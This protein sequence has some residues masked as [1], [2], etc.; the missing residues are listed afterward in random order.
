MKK[1]LALLLALLM[2]V[3]TL[4]ACSDPSEDGEPT[5]EPTE[6][7]SDTNETPAAEELVIAKS[8]VTTE[9]KVIYADGSE[10]LVITAVQSL[11]KEIN[12]T[13]PNVLMF[14]SAAYAEWED[15]PVGTLE[16]LVGQTNRPESSELRATLSGM[17]QYAIKAFENGRIAICATN[18]RLLKEAV[19]YFLNTYVKNDEDGVLSVP[20]DLLYVYDE[21]ESGNRDGWQLGVPAYMGGVV[22][23]GVYNIG[24]GVTISSDSELGRMHVV[25]DTNRADFDSYL[26]KLKSEGYTE[27]SRNEFNG[28]VFVQYRNDTKRKMVYTYLLEALSEVRVI[29]ETNSVKE[30]DFEYSYTPAAG[31]STTVYQYAMMYNRNGNGNQVGDPYGNNGMFYII[32]LSDNK[33]ILVDG[34]SNIQATDAATAELMKFLREI[35]GTPDTEKVDIAAVLLSH[36]HGDHKGFL[37]KLVNNYADAI[38]I[39]RAMYNMPSW[40]YG[41]F[42]KLGQALK[43]NFPTIKFIKPH[44][45][46]SIQL[47]DITVEIITTHEDNVNADTGKTNIIDFNS[48]STV[49]RLKIN[50]KTMMV[51]GDWGGGDTRA[52][53]DYAETERR[54]LAVYKNAETGESYL[55][56]DI[57]QI[58]HHAL[59]P[60]M[61]NVNK[62]V[63][64]KYAF[65]PA[66]DVALNSQ[67]HPNVVNVNYNQ[68][69]A[70]GGVTEQVYFSSRYTYALNIAQDGTIVVAAENIRGADTGDITGTAIVEQ[71][72][73][74]VTLKVYEAYRIPT[75]RE[76]A[77][78]ELIHS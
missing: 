18:E 30:T 12:E 25:A 22:S 52:P 50:G 71:D 6:S 48:T 15:A 70:A 8:G 58:S 44:T 21:S 56:S 5:E 49:Y 34:G 3:P 4:A 45:G 23:S 55:K 62:A 33:L 9:Y 53:A 65:F 54:L 72:Y 7:M 20:K 61:E 10:Q 43:E 29:E 74:N 67:A 39:E 46:Q 59:N 47:A 35:T 13:Y 28:N 75:D 63:A 41:S 2:L 76:F 78:W 40:D 60:Y 31:E 36:A 57:I 42:T 64:A 11:V 14:E 66:A 17:Y 37:E 38:N 69:I 19:V 16:I 68:F 77:N 51:M 24:P 73:V 27:I 26:T 32:R 1:L